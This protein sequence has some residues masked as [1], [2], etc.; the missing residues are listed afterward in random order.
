MKRILLTGATGFVGYQVAQ[1]LL[2][3]GHDLTC[4]IRA[5]S[6]NRLDGLPVETVTTKDLFSET[7]KWWQR[8]CAG[9]DT[10]IHLAWY[11]EPGN[12]LSSERNLDCLSGTLSLARGASQAGIR[13]LVGVGT[14]FEYDLREGHVSVDTPLA[15]KTIYAATKAAAGTTLSVFLLQAGVEFLWARLF[16]LYGPR[17]D[18]RRLVPYLHSCLETGKV[19]ELG[20]GTAVKDYMDVRD[21]ASILVDDALSFRQGAT[22]ISS[23]IGISIRA[24]AEQIADDYGRRDL[25]RFGAREDNPSDPPIVVGIRSEN[26]S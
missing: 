17:E 7:P 26:D 10:V 19:A 5:G 22:N 11:A 25:L 20:S 2:E 14:C 21:A 13:R 12:Y 8:T 24:L 9:M 6:Q 23:G 18:P 15:P 16:Y 1:Q 4:V 3:K